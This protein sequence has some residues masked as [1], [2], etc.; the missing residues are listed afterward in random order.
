MLRLINDVFLRRKKGN[1]IGLFVE[2]GD[3]DRRVIVRYCYFEG[4]GI[5]S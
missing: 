1:V 5:I 3:D 2:L 4:S